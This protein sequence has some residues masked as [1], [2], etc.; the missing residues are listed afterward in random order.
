MYAENRD[1]ITYFYDYVGMAED[2]TDYDKKFNTYPPT[3]NKSSTE[4]LDDLIRQATEFRKQELEFAEKCGTHGYRL[5]LLEQAVITMIPLA[6]KYYRIHPDELFVS[7]F[8]LVGV[9]YFKIR[10]H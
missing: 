2:K 1:Y 8:G 6:D 4:I 9:H 5:Q 7:G 10:C 3:I